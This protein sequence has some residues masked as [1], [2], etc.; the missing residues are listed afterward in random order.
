MT[1]ICFFF[2]EVGED[3][4]HHVHVGMLQIEPESGGGGVISLA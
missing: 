1:N 4:Y 2:S 3:W